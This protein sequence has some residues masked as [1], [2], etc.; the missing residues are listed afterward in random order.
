MALPEL[1][2]TVNNRLETLL[3]YHILD[4]SPEKEFDSITRLASYI[5]KTPF[6]L[7]TFLD[8]ERQWIKSSIGLNLKET[9]L[10]EAFCAY[11]I[12]DDNIFQVEDALLDERFDDSPLVHKDPY[13]RFYAGAP[14][15]SPSGYRLGSICVL[16]TKPGRLTDEQQDALKVLAGEV[17]SHLEMRKK[18]REIQETLIKYEEIY[19]MFDSSAELHCVMD[20]E[21][22]I[23]M[24]NRSVEKIL[25][26]TIEETIGHPIWHFLPEDEIYKLLPV[27]ERGLRNNVKAFEV[28]TRVSAKSGETKW[29][30]WSVA[31]NRGKWYANGRDITYQKKVVEELE[32]LSLVASKVDN[33][34]IISIG[35]NVIWANEAFERITGYNLSDLKGK[36]LGDVLKGEKTD[37]KV[38]EKAREFTK[39]KMSFAV[40]LLAYRKDGEP[41]WISVINSVILNAAG[42]VD[43]EVEVII[44]ITARKRA[45]EELQ[46]LSMVASKSSTGV[47]IRNEKGNVTWVNEALTDIIGYQAEELIG[48]QLGDVLTGERTQKEILDITVRNIENKKPYS[49]EL[50]VYKKD[51]TPFW[52]FTSSTP[53]L[54]IEG[55]IERQVEIIVDITERKY[56]EEQLTL[57]SLVASKTM[58]GVV[59]S[60][61]TGSIKWVNEAFEYMSG[62]S[63]EEL[64]GQRAG[65]LTAGEETDQE[66][67]EYMRQQTLKLQPSFIEA[68]FY[69][70]DR[71]PV[72]VSVS[73]TPTFTADGSFDQQ[74]TIV[75]DISK[76]KLVEQELIKTREEALQL[77]KA[78]ETFLS[79]MS[80]EIR[81]PLNAVIGITHILMDDNP[82]EAQLE[83]LKIL[84]FSSQN[85]LSLINDVLDF[86][87]IETGN[88][89]L[90]KAD[91]NLKDLVSQTLNTLQFKTVDKDVKLKSEIDHRIPLYVIG[92][93]TRLYQI[94]INLLGNAVKFTESGEVKLKLDLIEEKE[95]TI[96]VSFEVSDTGIGIAPEK[97]DYI[98]E[99]YTQ[100]SSDTTRKYGGTGL[101]LAITKRLIELHNS[102]ITVDS[103]VGKGSSFNFIIEFE[104]SEQTSISPAITLADIPLNSTILV[105]DDNY[106]NRLLAGK[107]LG[108]WGIKV[109]FAENGQVALEQVQKVPY[110]MILMDLQM[111]VMDGLEATRAIRKLSGDYYRKLPIIALTA[112][113]VSKEKMK[114]FECGMNDFVMKPFIPAALYEKIRSYLNT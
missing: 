40:D 80:H 59:I 39:N 62:F 17:M 107:V 65:D 87:K 75:N 38:L 100:A 47:V 7:I 1:N 29:V 21:T 28:E 43:K 52:I 30:G 23:Q 113:I 15:L 25:G 109:D 102:Q 24:V 105:V 95:K 31:V 70:K 76:R 12:Q 74:V 111:P 81:T 88:M 49:V 55:E 50:L 42:E 104:Q 106:I 14:L 86:T 41:I 85:L 16:D 60:D 90:E 36:K 56:A 35:N 26:Y 58:N 22:N 92:D 72:W 33:G 66:Q 78:K 101:G 46:T 93:H 96:K 48:R 19:N 112:S 98:F 77:S 71:S 2:E 79:V 84:N 91:V 20:R 11:T 57:L 5:C 51:G 97:V 37:S 45:E 3:D 27:I 61:N 10:H 44:D 68:I 103:E 18:N 89:V 32:M 53:I 9:Q 110:D 6:A 108:K 82:T 73:N 94:L 4:T 114:I 69:R 8:S 34:V 63:L 64:K 67:L 83:N 13:I 99:T 54:N